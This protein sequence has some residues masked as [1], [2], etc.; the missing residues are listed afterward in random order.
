MMENEQVRET[1]NEMMREKN[2]L[3]QRAKRVTSGAAAEDSDEDMSDSEGS[4]YGSEEEEFD[5][6]ALRRRALKAINEEIDSE[7]DESEEA[8][9]SEGEKAAKFDFG[10]DSKT[11][12]AKGKG[13]D[14]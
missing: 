6:E 13:K 5:E 7:E 9:D 2:A 11:G 14:D 12:K 3:K 10:Q 1:Y 8:E 4:G